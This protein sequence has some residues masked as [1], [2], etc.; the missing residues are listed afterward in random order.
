MNLIDVLAVANSLI[1]F[2]PHKSV[3]AVVI[4]FPLLAATL[5]GEDDI[6]SLMSRMKRDGIDHD[7]IFDGLGVEVIGSNSDKPEQE[8]NVSYDQLKWNVWRY[9][10][11]ADIAEGEVDA[12]RMRDRDFLFDGYR[13]GDNDYVFRKLKFIKSRSKTFEL[14]HFPFATMS[15]R[16]AGNSLHAFL[17]FEGTEM[18]FLEDLPHHAGRPLEGVAFRNKLVRGLVKWLPEDGYMITEVEMIHNS[19]EMEGKALS[20]CFVNYREHEGRLLPI[21]AE[22]RSGDFSRVYNITEIGP[23]N[24]DPHYYTA[25]AIG[26]ETPPRPVRVWV[27]WLVAAVVLML[28]ALVLLKKKSRNSQT[29]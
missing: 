2:R 24:P 14:S 9:E 8:F 11:H 15:T 27:Y 12:A 4:V 23:A 5:V 19:P 26:L 29:A 13:I 3:L 16:I 20:H 10:Y 18:S 1:A 25:E 17:S 7:H 6:E 22:A 28:A 21:W